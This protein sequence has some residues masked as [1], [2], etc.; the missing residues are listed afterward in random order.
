ME[1]TIVENKDNVD[2]TGRILVGVLQFKQPW[3][4]PYPREA[5]AAVGTKKE[6]YEYMLN[7]QEQCDHNDPRNKWQLIRIKWRFLIKDI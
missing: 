6:A 5:G 2:I 7:L 4:W 1:S 3:H